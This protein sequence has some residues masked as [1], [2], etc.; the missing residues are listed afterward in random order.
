MVVRT[1]K[2]RRDGQATRAAI[3]DAAR[4]L[5]VELGYEHTTVRAIAEQAGCNAALISRYFGGK[6]E[7]FIAIVRAGSLGEAA[8]HSLLDEPVLSWGRA[9]V[10]LQLRVTRRAS[11]DDLH[12]QLLMLL[13]SAATASGVRRLSDFLVCEHAQLIPQL[14]GPDAELR[15]LL[16]QAQLVGLTVLRDIARLPRLH[17][18]DAE[19]VAQY[20]GP[21]VQRLL[22]PDPDRACGGQS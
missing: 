4:R 11:R 21:A 18:A 13:R 5:F 2:P 7:L 17:E 12:D 22:Q 20:L 3:L 19:T 15:S 1:R 8:K 6:A 16:V 14:A 9:L 10:R